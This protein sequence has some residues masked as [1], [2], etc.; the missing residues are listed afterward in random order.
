MAK[1]LKKKKR[2]TEAEKR[3]ACL[4]YFMTGN[5][6]RTCRNLGIPESSM[7]N[8][9]NEEWWGEWTI[10]F[11]E[12]YDDELEAEF[13]EIIRLA[14][15]GVKKGLIEGDEKLVYNP[16]TKTHEIKMVKPTAKE[17]AVIGAVMFDK[18]RLTL[19]KPTSITGNTQ[20]AIENLANQFRELS[21]TFNEK[22]INSIE[23]EFDEVE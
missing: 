9:R 2:Y 8:W 11:R 20:G 17:Q 15:T 16:H 18:R 4:E 21:K 12:D 22:K 1:R 6:K 19:N 10:K 3:A 5:H 7:R 23:G 14:H 13:G